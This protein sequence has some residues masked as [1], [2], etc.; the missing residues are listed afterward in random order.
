MLLYALHDE[1]VKD[2]GLGVVADH[3]YSAPYED[4]TLK[5]R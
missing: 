4:L 5:A 3:P 2:G 1:L